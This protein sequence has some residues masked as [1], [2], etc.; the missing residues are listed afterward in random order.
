MP[1]CD[2]ER[3]NLLSIS[4]LYSKYCLGN[5]DSIDVNC[6]YFKKALAFKLYVFLSSSKDK[7]AP[8]S[9]ICEITLMLWFCHAGSYNGFP[10][11]SN[12]AL[13]HSG[14][15]AK[16]VFVI[17]NFLWTFLI[18]SHG[19]LIIQ[20]SIFGRA[21]WYHS[22]DNEINLFLSL[23]IPSSNHSQLPWILLCWY[24]HIKGNLA[25]NAK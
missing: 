24:P 8:F 23:I 21:G 17:P 15:D 13:C 5:F 25:S 12:A 6:A 1:L 4:T 7:I 18:I 9:T 3:L 22:D 16:A 10:A 11:A 14:H 19:R 2:A 20:L